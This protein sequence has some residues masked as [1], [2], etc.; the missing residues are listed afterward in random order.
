MSQSLP[1]TILY[2]PDISLTTITT[3]S[4][5]GSITIIKTYNSN[6]T[7]SWSSVA[8]AT[9]IITPPLLGSPTSVST[10]AIISTPGSST[11]FT[12][13]PASPTTT[14]VTTSRPSKGVPARTVVGVGIGT[15]LAGAFLALLGLWV[16]L[17]RPRRSRRTGVNSPSSL[18]DHVGKFGGAKNSIGKGVSTSIVAL[19]DMPFDPA[20]DS[21]IRK[22]MQ[23][24]YE[25]I[26][27]HAENHYSAK[28]FEGRRDDLKHELAKGG[29]NDRAEPSAQTLAS[30][31]VNPITRRVAIR[32]IVA[33][34]ILQH[35]D[36]NSSPDTSLLP[37]HIVASGQALLK[38][39]RTPGEQEG[40]KDPLHIS[41]HKILQ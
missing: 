4:V 20:D 17:R 40:K 33:W 9:L 5:S 34:V 7:V 35:I 6:A 1:T 18:G 32:H 25:L 29:W 2:G 14:V 27:Q 24:L 26:H 30:L 38:I 16:F 8:T 23:D 39:R 31:L 22:S 41:F 11:S 10:N 19:D 36:L 12:T 37:A 3:T 15:T 28:N 21:Q 13:S